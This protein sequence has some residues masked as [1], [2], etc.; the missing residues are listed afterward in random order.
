MKKFS[1]RLATLM[2]LREADR[3]ER[4]GELAKAYRAIEVIDGR[5]AE[6][7]QELQSARSVG[8]TGADIG[9]IAVD[10]L[11]DYERYELTLMAEKKNVESQRTQVA[12]EAERRRAALVEADREVQVLD[13]LR[14]KQLARHRAEQQRAELRQLDDVAGRAHALG[15]TG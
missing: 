1:F 9:D 14:E 15:K 13:K 10:T 8:R 4:R 5:L 7:E 2:K 11:L 6:I 12:E 3:D